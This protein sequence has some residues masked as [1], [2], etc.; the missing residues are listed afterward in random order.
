MNRLAPQPAMRLLG[1]GTALPE[2]RAT[3]A[4]FSAATEA[5]CATDADQ[6]QKVQRIFAGTRVQN[7]GS[8][9]LTNG[10]SAHPDDRLAEAY[11]LAHPA[12][13]ARG[14]TV[15]Q[16]MDWYEQRALPLAEAAARAALAEAHIDAQQIKQLIVVSCTGFAAPG[17]DIRLIEALGLPPTIGRTMVGFMGCHGAV[18]GLRVADGLAKAAPGQPVLM[19]CAELCSV[20]FQYGYDAQ[21]IVANALFADGAAAVVA[22]AERDE[23]EAAIGGP[24]ERGSADETSGGGSAEATFG[25]GGLRLI[26][27]ASLIVPGSADAMTWHIRDHGFRMTLSPRVPRLVHSHLEPFL[28]PWLARHGLRAAD[29]AGWAIHPGGPRVIDAV[30][31]ALSLRDDAGD[32]SRAVLAEHGNMSSPTVLFILQRLIAAGTTGPA[33]MLAFGP[34]LVIEAALLDLPAA[35]SPPNRVNRQDA[36]SAKNNTPERPVGRR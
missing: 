13:D 16:R 10:E 9:M 23:R 15:A 4:Q 33:V 14:P 5:R 28:T 32:A 30:E 34:G 24:S 25:G 7:R 29:V 26:D 2:H 31:S 1:I 12:T 22:R 27:P 21:Q 11:P 8:V 36:K 6:R 20:H 17:L 18:N 19:V 3:Q 35:P